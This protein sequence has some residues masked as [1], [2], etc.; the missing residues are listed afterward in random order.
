MY[1]GDLPAAEGSERPSPDSRPAIEVVE[2][3]NGETVWYGSRVSQSCP[4]LILLR[5]IVNGLREDDLDESYENRQSFASDLSGEQSVEGVQ[6]F[7]KEHTRQASKGS[8]HSFLTRMYKKPRS[9]NPGALRPETKAGLVCSS[10]DM[11]LTSVRRSSTALPSRL[12]VSL[13]GSHAAWTPARSTSCQT[14]HRYRVRVPLRAGTLPR[15]PRPPDR[16]RWS[17]VRAIGRLR[18]AS[19]GCSVP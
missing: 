18:S 5:S 1:S 13:R 12:P 6:V 7:F 8:N 10:A 9:P 16:R 14:R 15:L 2:M 3:A 17:I 11:T 19:I 4:E